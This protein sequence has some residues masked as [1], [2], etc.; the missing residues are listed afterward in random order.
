M[1]IGRCGSLRKERVENFSEVSG[2]RTFDTGDIVHHPSAEY[3]GTILLTIE[4]QDSSVF[5]HHE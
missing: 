2:Q 5:A 4:T 3:L 1:A